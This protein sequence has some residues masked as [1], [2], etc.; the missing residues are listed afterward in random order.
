MEA[1]SRALRQVMTIAPGHPVADE[2]KTA[3]NRHFRGQAEE[4]RVVAQRA[5]QGAE[6]SRARAQEDFAVASRSFAAAEGSFRAGQFADSTQAFLEARDAFSRARRAAEVEASEA[7]AKA[8][9]ATP[10]PTRVAAPTPVAVTP[11]VVPTPL[12]ATAAPTPIVATPA[13]PTPAVSL[14]SNPEP[15]IRR[16]IADYAR[17]VEAKDIGLFRAVWPGLSAQQ[18]RNL[19]ESFK[20]VKSQRVSISIESIDV[21]GGS[22]SVQVARVDTVNG[23]AQPGR[24]QTFRLSERSGSW[25]IDAIGQ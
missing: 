23:Q 12:A 11:A 10:S 14:P 1:A 13:P 18:E 8:A 25:T 4:A 5:R 6:G 3:L 15:A 22:A 17:A 20:A 9:S 21:Q 2:L 19:R 7:A 16:V 24:R